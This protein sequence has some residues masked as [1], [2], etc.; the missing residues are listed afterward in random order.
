MLYWISTALLSAM[1]T[2]SSLAYLFHG[3][4]IEGVRELGFPGHFR[5]QLAVMKI[6]AAVL[7]LAPGVPPVLREWAYAGVALFLVTAIVA[8]EAHGDPRVLHLVNL[9]FLGLLAV[10]RL[11]LAER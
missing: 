8:H 5:V 1:L 10:S 4:T 7:L 2:A 9:A 6:V 3:G 11:H